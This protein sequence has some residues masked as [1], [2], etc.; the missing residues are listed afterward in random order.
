[1]GGPGSPAS[2][3]ASTWRA[4]PTRHWWPAS[5]SPVKGSNRP[6]R[7]GDKGRGVD[8]FAGFRPYRP[9]DSPRHLFWKAVARDQALLV[10]QFGGDRADELWLDWNDLPDLPPPPD[11]PAPEAPRGRRGRP[12]RRR[13]APG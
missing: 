5:A 9:G 6:K 8:D 10:K 3:E 11:A 7:S 1:M 13:R 12:G 2:R 4:L